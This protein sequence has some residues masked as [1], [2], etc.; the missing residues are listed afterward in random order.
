MLVCGPL[1]LNCGPYHTWEMDTL[2]LDEFSAVC[3]SD[4]NAKRGPALD[5]HLLAIWAGIT[6]IGKPLLSAAMAES[7]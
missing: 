5:H 2:E 3:G 6:A 7:F 1:S 4:E